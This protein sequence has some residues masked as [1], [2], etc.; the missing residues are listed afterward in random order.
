MNYIDCTQCFENHEY[1]M[2]FILS[3]SGVARNE[4]SFFGGGGRT[5]SGKATNQ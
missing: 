1:L 2:R 5:L 4:C 3:H